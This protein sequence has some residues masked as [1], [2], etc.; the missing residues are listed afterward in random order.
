MIVFFLGVFFNNILVWGYIILVILV[1][2]RVLFKLL[3]FDFVYLNI[4]IVYWL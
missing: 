3:K 2:K 4:L 1:I